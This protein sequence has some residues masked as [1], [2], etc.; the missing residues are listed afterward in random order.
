[1][2]TFAESSLP[3]HEPSLPC[4][5]G[6]TQSVGKNAHIQG[7]LS[8]TI[9]NLQFSGT[10]SKCGVTISSVILQNFHCCNIYHKHC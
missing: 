1:M 3:D 8:Q 6:N 10:Q 9:E 2:P 4:G 7:V 5:V